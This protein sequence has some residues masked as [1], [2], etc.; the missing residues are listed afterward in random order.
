MEILVGAFVALLLG[1]LWSGRAIASLH[2]YAHAV[3]VADCVSGVAPR[4]AA[5]YVFY[6]L[7]HHRAE[8]RH[9]EHKRVA[10]SMPQWQQA[11]QWAIPFA[12]FNPRWVAIR[13]LIAC[14][15]V[16]VFLLLLTLSVFTPLMLVTT[17][18]SAFA[19]LVGAFVCLVAYDLCHLW[20]HAGGPM[21]SD[22]HAL[23]HFRP[24][25]NFGMWQWHNRVGKRHMRW[26]IGMLLFTERVLVKLPRFR[27]YLQG[28]FLQAQQVYGR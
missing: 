9:I 13:T 1:Y 19:F 17:I 14:Q 26:T 15:S 23:H 8:S 22:L 2:R 18:V 10:F 11:L 25:E 3:K 16:Q 5:T 27:R 7:A 28:A 12:L 24:S 6:H 21:P 20:T 4:S